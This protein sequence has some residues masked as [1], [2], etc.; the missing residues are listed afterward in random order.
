MPT[1]ARGSGAGNSATTTP[2]SRSSRARTS[3]TATWPASGGATSPTTRP[4]SR[5]TCCTRSGRWRGSRGRPATGCATSSRTAP[6]GRGRTVHSGGGVRGPGVHAGRPAGAACRRGLHP[7][8]RRPGV[9]AYGRDRHRAADRRDRRFV[10]G[11]PRPV[12]LRARRH[13]RRGDAGR[14]RARRAHRGGRGA[15]A[16]GVIRLLP[17]GPYAVLAEVDDVAQA[18]ALYA[19]LRSADGLDALVALVPAARTVLAG[20][21][22]D[23]SGRECLDRLASIVDDLVPGAAPDGEGPLV[24]LDVRYDGPDLTATADLLGLSPDDL[25]R[26]HAGAACRVAFCGFAPGF[27]YLT[28]LPADLHVPR[29]DTPRTR[30]PAGAV[31]LAGEFCGVY[32]RESPGGW[33]LIGHTDAVP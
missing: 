27:G 33:R 11:G 19:A 21:R 26:R 20:A 12:H 18:Q 9:R 7:A 3:G 16:V 5:P 4:T 32:P 30:V 14:P 2:C 17:A 13:A 28:G 31:G 1:S 24:D 6:L 29:L 25:V 23:R 15:G 8:R 22:P 10:G